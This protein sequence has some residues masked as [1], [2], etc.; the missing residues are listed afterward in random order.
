M[1]VNQPIR[2]WLIDKESAFT[3]RWRL[4]DVARNAPSVIHCVVAVRFLLQLYALRKK[5]LGRDARPTEAVNGV[6]EII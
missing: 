2:I 1:L 5:I 3:I 6:V 4:R